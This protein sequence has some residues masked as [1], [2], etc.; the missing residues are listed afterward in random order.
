VTVPLLEVRGLCRS[1]GR[2][3]AV[4]DVS[5]TV[6]RGQ[7]Y[8]FIGPNGAG[9]TTTMRMLATLDLP[10]GGDAFVEGHS[11]LSE[12]R[13]A[14]LRLGF[15]SDAFVPYANL[16]VG[17]FLDFVAR[18][19]GLRGRDRL[20]TVGSAVAFC[21]LEPLLDRPT[22]GLSKG[23]SQRLHL[24]KTLLHD[25][26]LLVLDEPAAGLDPRAVVDFRGLVRALAAAGKG[27]LISSHLLAELSEVSDGVV[28]IERGKV[29]VTGDVDAIAR[30]M[31]AHRPVRMRALSG[32]DGL[33]RFLLVQPL[34]GSVRADDGQ[35]AFDF[36]GD[37]DA[38]ADLLGRAVSAGLRVVELR[39]EETDLEDIFMRSTEGRLQ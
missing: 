17:Q 19:Y 2:V 4:D 25:P 36:E 7:V 6:D 26:A 16:T 15:M 34:V 11:I 8:G 5:F 29:V 1:F 22:T 9:K 32:A 12:P 20:R 28:L 14:R 37:D 30:G 18:A 13:R 23:M 39:T 27:I 38:L 35:V 33:E 21:G 10:D 31:R 24:A 3:R